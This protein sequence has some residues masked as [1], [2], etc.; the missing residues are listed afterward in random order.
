MQ[1][2][3]PVEADDRVEVV[4]HAGQPSGGADVVAGGEQVAGVQADAEPLA[5]AGRSISRASSSNER[6]SVPPAPAVS[7]R[8]SGQ[9]LG[10]RQRLGDHL[11]G[12]RD[13]L[14]DRPPPFSAEPG[15]STTPTAPSASPARSEAVSE[16]SDLSRISVSSE[17][18]LS[19]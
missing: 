7:S 10:L 3:E 15:C 13:R 2:A 19:R 8:C 18:Q 1:R 17:A 16:V 5:A 9:S 4:E 12:A 14:V 6:P 11:R